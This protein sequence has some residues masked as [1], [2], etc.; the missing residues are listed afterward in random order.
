MQSPV[1]INNINWVDRRLYPRFKVDYLTEVYMGSEI[2]FATAV[3]ISE[4]GI[5]IVLPGKF[6]VNEILNLRIKCN[7][8]DGTEED[9][10]RINLCI[11]AWIIWIKNEGKIYRAGLKIKD[12]DDLDLSRLKKNIEM[13]QKRAEDK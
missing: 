1:T 13:L 9:F 3:D 6:S 10:E 12:I 7:L 4:N 11:T 2:L 5:S 8:Y